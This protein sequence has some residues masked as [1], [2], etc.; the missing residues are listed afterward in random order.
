M[1]DEGEDAVVLR[2]VKIRIGE[3]V[4]QWSSGK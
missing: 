4:E 2:D 1:V 3:A